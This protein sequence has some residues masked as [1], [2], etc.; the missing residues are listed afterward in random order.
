MGRYFWF[1]GHAICYE[2]HP[3]SLAHSDHY[4]VLLHG[5]LASKYC[6]RQLISPLQRKYHVLTIDIPPFGDSSKSKECLYEYDHI[7]KAIVFLLDQLG[8]DKT[9]ILGHSM[10][11]QIALRCG[12]FY[13]ERFSKLI[14]LSPPCCFMQQSP[15]FAKTM[16]WNPYAPPFIARGLL[17]HKGVL[18]ILRHCL[19][20]D[21]LITDEMLQKYKQPFLNR[22]IYPSIVTWLK[23]HQED[24]HEEQLQKIM[25]D[26][27]IFWGGKQDLILP[28]TLGYELLKFLKN[29]KLILLDETGHFIPEEKPNYIQA[30][31]LQS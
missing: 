28:Y 11:G 1:K 4:I 5:F 30:Y 29:A 27:T 18:E 23:D 8:I 9:E 20:D 13:P 24:L 31:L 19:Y 26:C 3:S 12:Y 21:T 14:L 17:R 6:F 7:V 10:G 25:H 22:E 2:F 16:G 15:L